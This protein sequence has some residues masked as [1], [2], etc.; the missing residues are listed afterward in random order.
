MGEHGIQFDLNSDLFIKDPQTSSYGQKL[1]SA[2]ILLFDDLGF[3]SFTFK[4]LAQAISST[5]ASIY[6]YFEN[7][8]KLLLYL[9][10]WYWEWVGYLINI[11]LINLEDPKKRLKVVIHQIV[12]A[13]N[14]SP[15]TPYVNE[16]ILHKVII[17]E[18]SKAYHIR[19]VDKENKEGLFE[20]YQTLVDKVACVIKRLSPSFAYPYMLASNLFEMS[21]NQIFFAEHLPKLTDIKNNKDKYNKLEEAMCHMCFK[22]LN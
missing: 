20:S 18:S 16:N 7:K 5:E 4:K 3:E 2:S 11:H 19:D 21:N 1:L 13:S 10:N 15:L 17:Q 12:N 9:T 22:I 6:R 8:H 14:E